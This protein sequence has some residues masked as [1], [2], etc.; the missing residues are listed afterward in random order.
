MTRVRFAPSPVGHLY[1]S[2]ARVALAN[3][4]HARRFGGKM[5]LR[6]DDID[7]DR[8]K[9]AFA[10]AIAHDLTWLGIGWD[11]TFQQSDRLDLYTKAADL[12]RAANRI[13]PCFEGDDELRAKRDQQLQRRKSPIYDRAMLKLT[14]EQRAKAEA[15]GKQPYWRFMLSPRTLEWHDQILGQRKAK[16]TAVS[17]PVVMRADGTPTSLFAS[18]VDDIDTGI[19]LVI[20]AEDNAANTGVQ[21]DLWET[22]TGKPPR[23]QFAH[24]PALA[25]TGRI[26]LSRKVGSLS[27]RVLRGDGVDPA[28]LATCLARIG[29]ASAGE[30]ASLEVLARDFDLSRLSQTVAGFDA[31]Q[32]LSLNRRALGR[33]DFGA[34]ADRLPS[35]ATEA[36]WLAVR[37]SLDLMNEVRGWWEVVAGTIVPPVIDG[38]GRFLSAAESLLPPEPWDESVWR[39]WTDALTQATGRVGEALLM[40]LRLAL[41]G[42]EQGPALEALLPLMG[43][44]RASS[45][46]RKAAA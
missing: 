11:E 5:L 46:L 38:E 25:D 6:F 20:R 39:A 12:L 37:G 7:R 44:A 31:S 15:N 23:V 45:R 13:Y 3:Y 33:L 40:P 17:D 21:L 1:V 10:E 42:E 19:A 8:A 43:R 36:F 27:V 22:L 41:T 26:R 2:G 4:L 9:P 14:P 32:L 29:L 28:A 35:G 16:L 34:I 24:L 30:P 18:V